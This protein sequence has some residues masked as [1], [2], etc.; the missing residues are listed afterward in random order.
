MTS[1]QAGSVPAQI[2]ELHQA[3]KLKGNTA[4]TL[5]EDAVP[6]A[7][8]PRDS[9][10]WCKSHLLLAEQAPTHRLSLLPGDGDRSHEVR[11]TRITDVPVVLTC[12]S[13]GTEWLTRTLE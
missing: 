6:V 13:S 12:E 10:S 11:A 1:H 9:E 3:G 7:A 8:G 2:T 4:Q 5:V